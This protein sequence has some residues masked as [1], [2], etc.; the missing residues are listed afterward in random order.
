M[1]NC[2]N[3]VEMQKLFHGKS[4]EVTKVQLIVET[5]IVIVDVNVVDVNVTIRSKTIEKMCSRIES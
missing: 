5:Q 3:F 4:M 1:T 2:P